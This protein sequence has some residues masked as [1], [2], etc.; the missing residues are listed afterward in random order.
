MIG[1]PQPSPD[2]ARELEAVLSAMSAEDKRELDA[3]L[4]K[5]LDRPANQ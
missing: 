2:F 3:L 5:E 4:A 1:Y